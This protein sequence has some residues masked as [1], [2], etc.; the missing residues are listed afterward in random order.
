MLLF[1]L[2]LPLYYNWMQHG[3]MTMCRWVGGY[4]IRHDIH[5]AA[6]DP[7]YTLHPL[8]TIE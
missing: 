5:V 8:H 4:R 3:Q 2:P 7:H 6:V 1:C